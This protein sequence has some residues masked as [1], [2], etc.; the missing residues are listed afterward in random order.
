MEIPKNYDFKAAEEKW[1]KNWKERGVFGFD[2]G[3]GGEM[4]SID[5]PPPTVSGKLHIG[6]VFS[7][8]QT[9]IIARYQR[10]IGKNVLYPFG[11]DDNG[12]PTEM[13]TERDHEIKGESL[14]REEFTR[15]CLETSE[16]YS[17]LFKSL[18]ESLGF[19]VAWE[20]AYRTISESSRR[21]SQRS[22]LDL[23]KKK[24]VYRREMPT[25]W[26]TRCKTSF[27][28][29]EIEDK[30]KAGTFHYLNFSIP[31]GG[32]L[33][34]ATTRPELLGS[35]VAV[36]VHPEN[37]KFSSFIGGEAIVPI[38]GQTVP[39]IG[40]P[41]ADPEKGTG[42]VMCCTF[43][44]TT[45]IQW[46]REHKLP[47]RISFNDDGTMSS[48]AGAFAG[49]SRFE[50]RKAIVEKLNSEGLIFKQEDIPA[51]T[52]FVNT[53]ERCGNEVEYL[54]K[55]QW[56]VSVVDHKEEL[57]AQGNKVNWFPAH[58]KTRYIH[59]V[60]NLS[61]D[62]AISR[63]RFFGVPIPVW[64]CGDCGEVMAA[65]DDS[66]PVNPMIESPGVPCGCGST[67]FI[68]ESD[69]LDTWAT[70]SCTPQLNF[71]WGE[72]NEV[73]GIFPMSMR[74]QAHDIIR[75]WAFYTIVKAWYH[76][77]DIPWRDAVISGHTVKKGT[78]TADTAGAKM[79]G[80][81]YARKSK[82][83]KSKDGDRF[84]PQRLIEEYSADA[85][86]YWTSSGKLGTDIVFDETEVEETNRLLTK[87]W[88][89][90]RFALKFLEDRGKPSR[91][92][93]LTP[94]DRWILTRFN[95]VVE[96]YHRNFSEYEFFPPR[97]ELQNFFWH[98]FCDNYIEFV[99]DRFYNTD[100]RDASEAD[101]ARYTLYTVLLGILK[102]FTPYIP[103]I[104]EEIFS[105]HFS[106]AEAIETI[107]ATLMPETDASL[108]D[109]EAF[110]AGEL[111]GRLVTLVRGFKTRNQFS[112]MLPVSNLLVEG[113][114]SIVRLGQLISRDLGAIVVAS[115]VSFIETG[116]LEAEGRE[117][118]PETIDCSDGTLRIH[119]EMDREAVLGAQAASIVKR[120]STKVKKDL[121]MKAADPV[122]RMVV[123]CPPSM[124]HLLEREMDRLLFNTKAGSIELR[125]SASC[126]EDAVEIS[127]E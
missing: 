45:D 16:K 34:I 114:A 99:K 79:A 103:H 107:H 68:P 3:A 125:D 55:N 53:H 126:A 10:M 72:A 11:F 5:T 29:A 25:L 67:N 24:K 71:R 14:T 58:M 42:V 6:H 92:A 77:G 61:W 93:D 81:D 57:I 83:S 96:T 49:M 87:L 41:K 112:L 80:K 52:R 4:F 26:C 84:S 65:S 17:E 97:V 18:F 102:M 127:I 62:W 122:D 1:Q 9:D 2:P 95:R 22:F 21:I 23:L 104:T 28:Q 89:A 90:S 100:G 36:F 7:Y 40:D 13:L 48:A 20:T 19:S 59:W 74:P 43:G 85:I 117:F 69:V 32:S 50:A 110:E 37:P 82:I 94:V 73:K 124:R 123:T 119:V 51:E 33:P 91:P 121:G 39:I 88:N 54:V 66:L 98:D 64:Y 63:Q 56:F 120:E 60:E 47:L 101:A 8:T 109:A 76:F 105:L 115:N 31:G 44:D 78:G 75:T 70:S 12:L 46:W 106:Q 35:C 38:F 86:R 30:N 116:A 118:I 113:P 108:E 27:A 111:L 15:L